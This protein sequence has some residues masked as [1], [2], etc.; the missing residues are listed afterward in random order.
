MRS[1]SVELAA[2]YGVCLRRVV[3]LFANGEYRR[4]NP[5]NVAANRYCIKVRMY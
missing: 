1:D 3:A 4:V 2:K 5:I